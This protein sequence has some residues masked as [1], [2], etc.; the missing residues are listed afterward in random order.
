[1]TT[2]RETARI[3]LVDDEPNLRKV[4][5]AL[6]HQEGYEV[7]AEPDGEAGLARIRAAPS[8]TFDAVISD[9]R[10]PKLDGMG[11]LRAA[12]A[13]DPDL[14]II[15]LTAHGTVDSAVEAV[16]LGAFDYLE[17]PFDRDQI[18]HVLDR[19]LA[20]RARRGASLGRRKR[21]TAETPATAGDPSHEVGMIGSSAEMDAVREIVRTAAASPTTVLITGESGTGKELV[22]RALHLGSPR[23]E[24]P[25]IRVNCAAIPAGLVESELFGHER[26]AFTGAVSSR[27]GRFELADGGTLFLD[28]VSEIPLEIQVKLLRAIQ[29]SEFERVGG[30]KT[31][32]VDVR[33]IAAS[34]RDLE[35]DIK[36]GRFREDLYYRLNVVPIS[37]PALRDRVEDLPALV[38]HFVLRCNERL[39]KQV[40]GFTE[41]AL[42]LLSRYPWPGNIREL[43][44]LAERMVL[45]ASGPVVEAQA[46]PDAFH[47][48]TAG[49]ELSGQLAPLAEVSHGH[50]GGTLTPSEV[51]PERL[52][53]LPLAS[54]GLDLKEAV[55]AGSRLVEEALITEALEQTQGNVTRSARLL[56]ISRRS[57]QSKMKELGLRTPPEA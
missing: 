45:F 18:R 25:F 52:L 47:E 32:R 57:L 40:R 44:N 41:P 29:E 4:L 48:L 30:V 3:L 13:E 26:G 5:G 7:H 22:A 51:A 35:A 42:E 39:G 15:I 12:T 33:L 19:A 43:E 50:L 8:G 28:E 27:A 31:V 49:G 36:S 56:G 53:R 34:N 38:Q 14:P 16:K 1:M 37:L 23:R 2:P 6:L 55:R 24:G 46:L 54:L 9:L 17:K 11:L 21:P 20:T 10:M